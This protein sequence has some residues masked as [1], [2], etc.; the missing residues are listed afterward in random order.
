MHDELI[1]HRWPLFEEGDRGVEEVDGTPRRQDAVHADVD[2]VRV[3]LMRA[4]H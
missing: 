4:E 1:V 2:G 3:V